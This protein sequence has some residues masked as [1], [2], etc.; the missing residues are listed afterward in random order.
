MK[1]LFITTKSPY[2]LF[3]GR[4]L[5]TFNLIKEVARE[6]EV[7]LL[8]F[9]QTQEDL[10]GIEHMR[11][12]CKVVEYEKLYFGAGRLAVLADAVRDIFS[13]RP[14]PILKYY[15]RSMEARIRRLIAAH[16]YDVIH[17]D[18]LHLCEYMDVCSGIPVVLAQHNVESM[19]LQRRAENEKRW[20][21]RKYLSRQYRKL[22][23]YEAAMCRRVDELLAVSDADA[24]CLEAMTGRGDISVAPNG[25]DTE[26]F[27]PQAV[28]ADDH[29]LVF[30]GGFTWFPN[31]DAIQYFSDEILPL[32]RQ[33]LPNIR[34]TVIGRQPDTAAVRRVASAPGLTLTGLIDDI[35][36]TVAEAGAYIVPLRIGGG[37]RL[38]IL[39]A[40]A[41]SK[42]I[43]STSIGCEGLAVTHGQ[44]IIVADTPES[45]ANAVIETLSD[46]ARAQRI[47]AA[48]RAL[49]VARYGWAAIAGTLIAAYASAVS[50]KAK[51]T[52]R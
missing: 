31:L 30:V 16:H 41:M 29:N 50:R 38:K 19:I 22:Q 25:V 44:D 49:V 20:L 21:L 14:L 51:G 7:H 37:T 8:S 27:Q 35:R 36:P 11:S 26:F 3:E 34:I 18:M 46:P 10:D 12:L 33:K 2:P 42:A 17:L 39:D 47:G 28:P 15:S 9:V 6:H 43:I 45:F 13:A 1:V 23:T 52:A 4:A 48:G 40:L 24:Q 5:R 32:V